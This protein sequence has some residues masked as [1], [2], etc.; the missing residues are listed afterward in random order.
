MFKSHIGILIK[1]EVRHLLDFN[2]IGPKFDI[3]ANVDGETEGLF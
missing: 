3:K 1:D 2:S